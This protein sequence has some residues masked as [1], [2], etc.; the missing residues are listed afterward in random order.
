M[1]KSDLKIFGGFLLATLA[2][3]IGGVLLFS[4]DAGTVTSIVSEKELI[5]PDN[6]FLGAK[7]A[8]VILVE[9]SDYECPACG[10]V[11]PVI[12]QLLEKYKDKIRFVYRHFPLPQHSDAEIAAYASES[13]GNQGK[14]W[15]MHDKLFENQ[16]N[17]KKE[18]ILKYAKELKLD[19]EKFQKNWESPEVK[20]KVT[21][22]IAA[23]NKLG[24]TQTPTFFLNGIKLD[25]FSVEEIEKIISRFYNQ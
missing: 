21:D 14:F 8:K 3:I 15:E 1:D 20:Q 12:K 19:L 2:I 11:H 4:K 6:H 9:F 24:I 5:S 25:N 22:D 10:A 7:N 23:G 13:A 18:D 17:L 16:K